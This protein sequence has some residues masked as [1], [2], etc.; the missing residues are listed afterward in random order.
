MQL[1]PRTIYNAQKTVDTVVFFYM[2]TSTSTLEVASIATH[3]SPLKWD[4]KLYCASETVLIY[5]YRLVI[6]SYFTWCSLVCGVLR[7][8]LFQLARSLHLNFTWDFR[9]RVNAV[10]CLAGRLQLCQAKLVAHGAR[11][12]CLLV[13]VY[14]FLLMLVHSLTSDCQLLW[15]DWVLHLVLNF[16]WFYCF[17]F[18]M[19]TM[20]TIV[21]HFLPN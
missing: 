18:T 6:I 21:I 3:K 11:L 12:A 8:V 19:V 10:L 16:L 13:D 1:L 15:F 2:C 9:V 5:Q 17:V 4:S 7:H 20:V 14:Y